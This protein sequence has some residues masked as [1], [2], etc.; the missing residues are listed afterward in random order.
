MFQLSILYNTSIQKYN[1]QIRIEKEQP[2]KY[3]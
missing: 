2:Q 3:S 1:G